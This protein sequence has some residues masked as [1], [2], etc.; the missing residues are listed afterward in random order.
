M[1]F[2]LLEFYEI[3]EEPDFLPPFIREYRERQNCFLVLDRPLSIAQMTS[4][5]FNVDILL[6]ERC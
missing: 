1:F 6:T 4:A 5:S 2:I 3:T